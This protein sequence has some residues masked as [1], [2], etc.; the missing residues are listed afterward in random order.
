MSDLVGNPEDRFSRVAAHI[1]YNISLSQ[2]KNNNRHIIKLCGG[3]REK[4][5]SGFP[6][7]SDTNRVV[8]ALKMAR[9]WKFWLWKVEE[10]Y[11]PCSK[12]KGT[13]QLCSNCTA[14]LRLCFPIGKNLVF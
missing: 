9:G 7:R 3:T 6:T 5:S 13:E 11:Y 10:L 14:D 12:N 1:R 4:R 2:E 8:Q